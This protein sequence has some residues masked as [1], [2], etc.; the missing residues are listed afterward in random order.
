MIGATISHYKIIKKLGQGGMGIV[1]QAQD[2]KLDRL[3]A[4]KFLPHH[5]MANETERARFMQ[6]AKAASAL[7]HPNVCIIHYIEEIEQQQFIVMEYVDGAT[8]R[9]KFHIAPLKL[10]DALAYAVQIGEALQEAHSKGIVHRDIKSDNIMVN[11]KNQIKVMD[12]GLAKL[13]G[14]LKL[15][16]ASSTVGTLSYMA[17]EQIQGDEADARSDIFSFGVVVYEMLTQ[18][19]PF[20]GEHEAAIVYSI[21]NEEPEP[22]EKYRSDLPPDSMRILKRALEKDPEDR[23]QSVADMVSEL[24]RLRK[25]TTKVS[26]TTSLKDLQP[27]AISVP[28]EGQ[29]VETMTPTPATQKPKKSRWISIG[30]LVAVIAGLI[31]LLLPRLMPFIHRFMPEHSAERTIALNPN[32]AFHMVQIPLTEIAAPGFSPDGNWVAFPAVDANNV[33]DI[34]YMNISGGEP[35]RVTSDSSESMTEADISP[36]GG[37]IVYDR[38]NSKTL[39]SEVCV[40]SALGGVTRKIADGGKNPRWRPDGQRIGYVISPGSAAEKTAKV[41]FRSVQPDG[42]D[43]R[44]EFEQ[45]VITAG[46]PAT[47]AWSPDGKSVALTRTFLA[48]YQEIFI[49]NLGVNTQRQL[50][51]DEK[52]IGDLCWTRN[53]DIIFSSEKGGNANLWIVPAVGGTA[54]Q[55]TKGSGPDL[56]M[57]ISSDGKKLLYLQQQRLGHVWVADSDANSARQISFGDHDLR[58]A[59]L[60]PDG[61][62]VALQIFEPDPLKSISHIYV[63]D[64]DGSNLRQLT[65]GMETAGEPT[66]SLD[67]RWMAYSSRSSSAPAES[68]HVYCVDPANSVAPKL[69][70]TGNDVRWLDSTNVITFSDTRSWRLAIEGNEPR[71]VYEDS[72]QAIEI[73]QGRYLFFRDLHRSR[74][75]WW[76]VSSPAERE[77]DSTQALLDSLYMVGPALPEEY[78]DSTGIPRYSIIRTP[79]YVLPDLRNVVL[80]P[81][82][83]FLIYVKGAGEVWKR[84]LPHGYEQRL[85][86][87]LIG[88]DLSMSVSSDGKE[89]LYVDSRL[90]SKLVM[91]ENLY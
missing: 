81:D 55:V 19:T 54:V 89:I 72:T 46:E 40:V 60:S 39:R 4:L 56:R 71:Q 33:W 15:T 57:K 90:S 67:G 76:I 31:Y 82:G 32:M 7:N 18:H 45:G 12:F 20:R 17:P 13:K 6:E 78:V 47:F 16:R 84:S 64:R 58:A 49:T 1:Y 25:E 37:R 22:I 66:W 42:S 50:T 21:V 88:H 8:L 10:N 36:D 29:S 3:V 79:K 91:V 73:L 59:S 74:K 9:E 80:G 41:E 52:N 43:P 70:G 83:R 69:I 75:G 35:R 63:S 24:R 11:S 85:A 14:S 65:N 77:K 23:Y 87:T 62:H 38:W 5:L 30:V 61:K 28:A 51:F 27:K 68:T 44:L 48:G 34:Y 86:G 53:D 26:R 2:T